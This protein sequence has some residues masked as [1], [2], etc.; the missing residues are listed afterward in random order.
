MVKV[1]GRSPVAELPRVEAESGSPAAANPR[2][3]ARTVPG[4]ADSYRPPT[5]VMT[6]GFGATQ[7]R[8]IPDGASPPSQ[9]E[10]IY[11][12]EVDATQAMIQ[13]ILDGK[14]SVSVSETTPGWIFG[15][16]AKDVPGFR[17]HVE[18]DLRMLARTSIGR[19]L[20]NEISQHKHKVIIR[21]TTGGAMVKPDDEGA[22]RKSPDGFGK[23]SGATVLLPI[24]QTDTSVVVY[25]KPMPIFERGKM[26]LPSTPSDTDEIAQPRFMT[27]AHELVHVHRGQR[28]A[29]EPK[30]LSR[31]DGYTNEE[32]YQAITGSDGFT[33]NKVREAYGYPKR[34]GHFYR[35][36]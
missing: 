24:G 9:G 6:S 32:E 28:G 16:F 31:S 4:A 21:P 23:G 10:W 29:I 30:G 15:L 2:A 12:S 8:V 25:R 5:Y 18:N 3:A 13:N 26:T 17:S 33:E 1:D 35:K 7:L 22:A 11:K 27:L 20:I 19:A 36:K 34:Y 14:G